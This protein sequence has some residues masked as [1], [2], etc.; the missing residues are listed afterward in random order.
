MKIMRA[1]IIP[2]LLAVAACTPSSGWDAGSADALKQASV[3]LLHHLDAGEFT[4]MIADAD[5]ALV[6]MDFDEN[7]VPMRVDG[8]EAARAF[9]ARLGESA[10]AQNIRFKSTITRNDAWATAAMGYGIVEYDQTITVGEQVMGPFKFRGTLIA[11][12]DAGKWRM[13]QWHGS[14]SVMPAAAAGPEPPAAPAS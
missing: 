11:R 12:R 13:T 9:F 4:E 6:I 3:D 1:L 8:V 10:K 2:A 14:F 5:P 7:N